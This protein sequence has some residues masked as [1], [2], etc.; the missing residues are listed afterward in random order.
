MDEQKKDILRALAYYDV[1]QFPLNESEIIT[2]G[3]FSGN[4]QELKN[5]LHELCLNGYIQNWKG[6]YFL[7]T[8]S[9]EYVN[10]RE[11]NQARAA[12]KKEKVIRYSRLIA[13]FP[14]VEC[15]C[16]S[17]SYSK[18][19]LDKKGD[20]DY[21]IISRPG[22]LWLTRT[23]LILYKKVFLFNSRKYFCINYLIDTDTLEIPDKNIFT[24][25]EILTLL[26]MS[27]KN[28]YAE[29][30]K[31]NEWSREFLPNRKP[32]SLEN[33][34]AKTE[35]AIVATFLEKL[36][37]TRIGDR[38][39]EFCYQLTIRRWRKKFNHFANDEFDL[40]MRSRKNVSKHHPRGFQN[41][42]LKK[43]N[44]RLNALSIIEQIAVVA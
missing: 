25:T 29:F 12:L 24:A 44:E 18:G 10:Q 37:R 2:F 38:L 26:P 9:K 34:S 31:Q 4:R 20:I 5:A 33:I 15:V 36:L 8:A 39:E 6:Y 32:P 16:I 17:G 19:V 14:F 23:L 42:V 43:Y 13:A 21:F 27:G 11:E 22:R 28:I 35:K 30:I 7:S 3:S 1:F 41:R 40:N